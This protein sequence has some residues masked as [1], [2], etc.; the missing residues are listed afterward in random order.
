MDLVNLESIKNR[1][2]IRGEDVSGTIEGRVLWKAK[3]FSIRG[4]DKMAIIGSNGTGKTTF[5]KKLF[6]GILVFHYRHLSK[7]VILAKNRYIR[8]R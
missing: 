6:M 5:I 8:I 1:T 4:G 2:I 3:I 7:S